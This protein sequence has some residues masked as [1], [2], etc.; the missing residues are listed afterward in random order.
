MT[1]VLSPPGHVSCAFEPPSDGPTQQQID[2][3]TDDLLEKP[4]QKLPTRKQIGAVA[5]L[6]V[7]DADHKSI[8]FKSLYEGKN[9]VLIIFVRHFFC[10]QCQEFLRTLSDSVTPENLLSLPTPTELIVIGCGQPELISYYKEQTHC[11]FPLYADPTRALY[12]KLGM[13]RTMEPGNKPEYIRKSFMGVAFSSFMQAVT[14]GRNTLKG[15][16]FWQVGGEFLFEN[17]AVTKCHRMSTTR[18]HIEMDEL[19]AWLGLTTDRDKEENERIAKKNKRLSIADISA[20]ARRSFS[21][22]RSP[23]RRQ[24]RIVSGNSS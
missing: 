5:A 24:G 4:T 1:E 15:G 17:E 20:A 6:P 19:K 21:A 8:P 13:A 14:A 2:K 3:I 18:D 16:D 23:N 11:K 9:R 12:T 7:L 10:G 22:R